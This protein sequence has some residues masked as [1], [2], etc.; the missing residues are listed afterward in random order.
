MFTKLK[1]ATT[2][3]A[4]QA[5]R[6]EVRVVHAGSVVEVLDAA[7]AVFVT[8]GGTRVPCRCPQHISLGWLAAAVAQGPVA[9]EASLAEDGTEGTLWCL[10]PGPEHANVRPESLDLRASHEVKITCGDSAFS[11]GK[12]GKVRLRGRDIRVRG[13]RVTR[14][15]G[16]TVKL[17]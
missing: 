3:R 6:E 2:R 7:A 11:L 10:L 15:Q 14:V 17:N 5:A 8:S 13:S 12:D 4:V 9:A 1:K 16:G